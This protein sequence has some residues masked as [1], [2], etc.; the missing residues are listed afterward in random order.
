MHQEYV[1]EKTRADSAMD[2]LERVR[3]DSAVES[4]QLKEQ[5]NELMLEVSEM[6]NQLDDLL[7]QRNAELEQAARQSN[8]LTED[9]LEEARQK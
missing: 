1:Y 2:D 3:N 8:E 7:A 5:I 9:L 4:S 6:N